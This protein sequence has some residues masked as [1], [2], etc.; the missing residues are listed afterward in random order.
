MTRGCDI[1]VFDF[2]GT[3]VDSNAIKSE[4]Y[5]VIAARFD[6]GPAAMAEAR[7]IPGADR[8]SVALRFAAHLGLPETEAHRIAEDYTRLVDDRVAAAPE[9]PGAVDLIDALRSDGIELRVSSATP[10]VSLERVV[11]ARGW[12]HFF[13]G[14]HGRP[15]TKPETLRRL[16]HERGVAPGRIVV[17]G[18]GE[19]DRDSAVECGARFIPVGDRLPGERHALAD[20]RKVLVA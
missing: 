19:D 15:A 10:L 2:D 4:G 11:A 5:D 14:L 13:D 1:V 3:L 7:K 12:A 20:V 18:D 16:I 6:G 8:F 17:I 9:I